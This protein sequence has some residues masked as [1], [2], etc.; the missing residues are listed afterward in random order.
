M[1]HGPVVVVEAAI[2]HDACFGVD[3]LVEI[4]RSMS[5]FGNTLPAMSPCGYLR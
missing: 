2:G 4:A 1:P 5:S 3:E